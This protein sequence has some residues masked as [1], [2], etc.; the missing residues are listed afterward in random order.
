MI[1]QYKMEQQCKY[2]QNRTWFQAILKP[3]VRYVW[4]RDINEYFR[5]ICRIK[6]FDK[7]TVY[8]Y[9]VMMCSAMFMT[10][11]LYHI[12]IINIK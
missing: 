11:T 5:S 10:I 8:W 7:Y 6:W 4:V 1:N 9:K 12:K 3:N 2:N